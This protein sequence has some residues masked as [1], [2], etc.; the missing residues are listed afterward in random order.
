MSKS[1]RSFGL[2]FLAGTLAL[3]MACSSKPKAAPAVQPTPA[4]EPTPMPTIIKAEPTPVAPKVEPED[5][6]LSGDLA[7]INA[8]GYLKDAFYDFDKYD[9][10]ED[11]RPMLTADA[12]WL[13]KHPSVKIRIEGHCDERGTSQYNL[14]LGEKRAS[15]AREYL[16]A[17]GVE[18]GR[19]ET[20]SYGKERPFDP[21]HDESA[22]AKNRRAHFVVIAK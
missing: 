19:I 17:L 5:T 15:A 6:T 1:V 12:D 14:A 9:I 13:R 10:R 11:Q 3:A 4:P 7:K 18:T 8:A 22:W 20:V 21:G 16:V 2:V